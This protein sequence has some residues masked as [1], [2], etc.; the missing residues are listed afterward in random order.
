MKFT[1]EN[2]LELL[3]AVA[4]LIGAARLL[5]ELAR[6]F[7]KP[8]VLGELIAG[9][10]LGPS[11]LGHISPGIENFLFPSEGPTAM[12]LDG[13][14]LLAVTLFLMV[15]GMEVDLPTILRHRRTA[16][17]VGLGALVL[18]FLLG[19][20]AA[21][22]A[23]EWLHF[24]GGSEHQHLVFALF[25]GTAL[26]ISALPVLAKILIDLKIFKTDP[27]M[28]I[29]A[30]AIFIDL[31]GWN[32]F[33]L[34]MSLHQGGEAGGDAILLKLSLTLGFAI[35]MLTL[36]RAAL[37]RMLPWVQ[38]H[39]SWPAGI[40]GFILGAGLLCAAF[41]QWL[42]IHS[43]FGA[44]LF[45]VALGDSP[46]LRRSVRATLEQF[47]GFILT[48]LFFA[49]IGLKID[50]LAD[51][52]LVPVLVLVSC[53]CL[54]KIPG[55]WLGARLCG[56]KGR[57]AL[58]VGVGMNTYGAMEIVLGLT[59]L[60]AGIISQSLFVAIVVLALGTSLC[61]S[62]LLQRVLHR[63]RG[64]HL[65]E[66]LS[67]T[68]F[69]R[70]LQS[71][72]PAGAIAELSQVAAE[73][74]RLPPEQIRE[75][76]LEREALMPTGLPGGLA[77]PHARLTPLDTPVIAIGLSPSGLDFLAPDDSKA[78]L[79]FLILTP[80]EQSQAQLELLSEIASR[81]QDPEM[82]RQAA[83][84]RSYTEFLAL[85]QSREGTA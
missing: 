19:L 77:V 15:A 80:N 11:V 59:A 65:V 33:G 74:C 13:I 64:I 75:A 12:A 6:R 62:S 81:F 52:A 44:F 49:S 24:A 61:T 45:G 3:L 53:A 34:V 54:G 16:L 29:I 18:P 43:L 32:L 42:G 9:I 56:M 83:E 73:R 23:P 28:V 38:A 22:F 76:V 10:L 79:I 27:G 7:N 60:Q 14:R 71:R 20:G 30:A 36:G 21:W 41:T 8:P 48:P 35:F 67:S 2:G 55:A 57:E 17:T 84:C 82:V 72:D 47:I 51:F 85:V 1:H 39:S 4:V 37:A 78:R 69:I 25:V 5:G 70:E 46:H 68:R 66:Q 63:P 26:G 31:I 50:F 40:L 58:A